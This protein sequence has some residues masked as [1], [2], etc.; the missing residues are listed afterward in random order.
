MSNDKKL[1][2]LLEVIEL[3]DRAYEKATQR[4][5]D[6]GEWFD[7]DDCSLKDNDPHIF[8][9]GSFALGTAIRPLKETEEYDLDLSCK[10]RRGIS[11]DTHSQSQLK[12]MVGR[13]LE[14]YRRY[15][16]IEERLEA[17]HRCWRLKY[18]DDMRFHLDAVPG[19]PAELGRRTQL[20]LLIEQRGVD[21]R[22]A[23]DIAADAVWITDDLKRNFEQVDPDWLSSNPEGYVRWF[24]SRMEGTR[25]ALKAEAQVDEV[26]LYRRKT[27]LQ[28]VIQL[29]KRHRDVMFEKAP[30]SK[31]I[32]IILTTIAGHAYIPGKALEE[33]MAAV[34]SALDAFRRSNSDEVLNPVNP[35]EN[36]ADRWKRPECARLL[37]KENFHA[38]VQQAVIFFGRLMREANPQ[39]I[40]EAAQRG[41]RAATTETTVAAALGVASVLPQSV[42]SAP[43][44]TIQSPPKP[45]G[46]VD[47]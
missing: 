44:I 47:K 19:I 12:E 34:L 15:R 23:A 38:W 3:P 10:L 39:L 14:G 26:P 25:G 6:L 43:R 8:V 7:R 5:D 27:P 36:F 1:Q 32:S 29:L 9:Q 18:K 16:H 28:R 35:E 30:D 21:P 41:L 45:W 46:P 42:P 4:Y 22:L 37:L 17:K 11:R 13:E 20:R 24:V 33:S 40:M 2:L 31:P